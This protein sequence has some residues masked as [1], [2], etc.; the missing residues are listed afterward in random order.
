MIACIQALKPL[1]DTS[2]VPSLNRISRTCPLTHR[3]ASTGIARSVMGRRD[4]ITS[5][6]SGMLTRLVAPCPLKRRAL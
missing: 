6:S 5:E 3:L 4:L 2:F 1:K